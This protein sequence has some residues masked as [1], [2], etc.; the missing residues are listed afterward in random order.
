MKTYTKVIMILLIPLLLIVA[1]GL[2]DLYL[3]TENFALEKV[4]FSDVKQ[5][6]GNDSLA[7]DTI[8]SVALTKP[9]EV[10][11][12]TTSQRILFFGDSMLEGLGRR[13]CDYA[14]ENGHE[15]TSVCWYSS[16]S[17]IWANT[18][19]LQYFIKETKP[20]FIMICLCSNEQFV[21]DLQKREKYVETII[22]KI[23]DI[24]YVWIS[25]PSWK[26][27]TGI[28]N[29]IRTKVGKKRYFDSTKLEYER[30]K[31]HVHPTFAS[32]EVWMDSIAVWM[33]SKKVEHPIKM[34]VPTEER[35][36]KWNGKYLKPYEQ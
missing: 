27:D 13:M 33:Q 12:D 24:P 25:P 35:P 21:R 7:A 22:D 30:G 15:Y 5:W 6:F 28:N 1:Y 4:D 20:T 32:A 2:S 16:T 14:L 31:D 3:P 36:R 8:D 34:A 18:D 9:K 11:L 26:E 19:T 17:E 10:E 23:G 29:I